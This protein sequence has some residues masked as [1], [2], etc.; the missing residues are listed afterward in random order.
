MFG[1][2]RLGLALLVLIYHLAGYHFAGW[3]SVYAFYALSGFLM[4]LVI[5]KKYELSVT[6]TANFAV[7]RALRIY[8]PYLLVVLTSL[9]LLQI[10]PLA[11]NARQL[12]RSPDI[13]MPQGPMGWLE[14]LFIWGWHMRDPKLVPQMWTV[15]RELFYC[16]LIFLVFARYR[17]L[18]LA[19]FAG[20]AVLAVSNLARGAQFLEVYTSFQMASLAY[21][22]GCCLYHFR[23]HLRR[24]TRPLVPLIC[25]VSVLPFALEAIRP[26]F[27]SDTSLIPFYW[28]IALSTYLVLLLSCLKGSLRMR[29]LDQYLGNLSYPVYLC[30]F[31][32]AVVVATAAGWPAAAGNR[33]LFASLIP[34]LVCSWAINRYVEQKLGYGY[35][36]RRQPWFVQRGRAD[37]RPGVPTPVDALAG[38]ATAK[39]VQVAEAMR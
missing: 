25:L 17:W 18:A 26:R 37:N 39:P 13:G 11:D 8:P 24:F 31:N 20:S 12:V 36:Q 32:V 23:P 14:N 19:W 28:N 2:F 4:T 34:I 9:I 6:G 16:G 1:I 38:T 7:N 33:L 35:D 5:V 22:A 10:P 30:H 3:Y 29:A 21:S 27:F 15:F